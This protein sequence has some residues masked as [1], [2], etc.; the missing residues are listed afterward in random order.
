MD[1]TPSIT[2]SVTP[3][4]AVQYF[5]WRVLFNFKHIN[6]N[7]RLADEYRLYRQDGT[8]EEFNLIQTISADQVSATHYDAVILTGI[9]VLPDCNVQYNYK[10]SAYNQDGEIDCINPTVTGTLLPC[11]TVTPSVTPTQTVTPTISVSPTVTPTITPTITVTP[12]IT[13]TPTITVSPTV[14]VTPSTT[15]TPTATVTP[16]T[17]VTPTVTVTPTITPTNTV[18][19]TVTPSVTITPT[20]TP[21]ITI[22]PTVTPSITVTPT[23]TPSN[24]VTPTITPTVTPSVTV[25]SSVLPTP[26]VTATVTPSITISPSITPSVTIS[27]TVTPSVTISP[28]VTPSITVSP[29]ITPTITP[30]PTVTPST[31]TDHGW[32]IV[33]IELTGRDNVTSNSFVFNSNIL[34]GD[35]AGYLN[36]GV[37]NA[38][39][40]TYTGFRIYSS[41]LSTMGG[42]VD[43]STWN[44]SEP[45][46]K[47]PYYWHDGTNNSE[48]A[49]VSDFGL[50]K[51]NDISCN[52]WER[53]N[54]LGN[55]LY[56]NSMHLYISFNGE[57]LADY[58]RTVIRFIGVWE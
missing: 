52:N 7:P 8:G 18:T 11:P 20:V 48:G 6:K 47:I 57:K 38:G 36:F 49:E 17:T 46:N 5:D 15:V 56:N 30:T 50:V 16:T 27:P 31:S 33:E 9:D 55:D 3:S 51:C 40:I 25:S 43:T 53:V 26:S 23:V 58:S 42:N 35:S 54:I 32:D 21:S 4:E 28:T 24:T 41:N 34:S 10:V 12:S 1:P 37:K 22:T 39:G 45:T 2:P 14:T 44:S 19:P 29:T 13:V